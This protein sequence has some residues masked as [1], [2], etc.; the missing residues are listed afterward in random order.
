MLRIR[1]K[2]Y[3]GRG[4]P[5]DEEDEE[6]DDDDNDEDEDYFER[7]T[8]GNLTSPRISPDVCKQQ[9]QQET[10]EGAFLLTPPPS[11]SGGDT[12]PQSETSEVNEFVN[13]QQSALDLT[14]GVIEAP[15]CPVILEQVSPPWRRQQQQEFINRGQF[16]SSSS[17]IS[18]E[19]DQ[20]ELIAVDALL[21]F[22]RKHSLGLQLD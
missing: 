18:Q 11:V 9:Q 4:N 6:E 12:P 2:M 1:G 22:G 17:N 21:S 10:G 14:L 5:T 8:V 15:S 20:A 7:R 13:N 16:S 3:L 19:M